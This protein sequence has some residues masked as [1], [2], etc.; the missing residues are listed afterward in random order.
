[1]KCNL[2]IVGLVLDVKLGIGNHRLALIQV[3]RIAGF[4]HLIILHRIRDTFD[5]TLNTL[6]IRKLISSGG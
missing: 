6:K 3:S 5:C 4:K 1:M 2:V